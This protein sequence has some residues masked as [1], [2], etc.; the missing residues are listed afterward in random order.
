[1]LAIFV[2]VLVQVSKQSL[3]S[4]GSPKEIFAQEILKEI[5]VF[6]ITMAVNC[7]KDSDLY[8]SSLPHK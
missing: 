5:L 7:I 6:V 2:Q 8:A 3:G 4:S 1:M